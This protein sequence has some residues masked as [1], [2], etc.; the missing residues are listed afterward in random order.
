MIRVNTL[1]KYVCYHP[2]EHQI[3]TT[4]TDR[5][6]GYYETLDAS[7]VR[8]LDGSSGSINTLDISCCGRYFVSAGDDK[9][10]KVSS[11]TH[12]GWFS[13]SNSVDDFKE[14]KLHK[15][16]KGSKR[17]LHGDDDEN[18][19]SISAWLFEHDSYHRAAA[20]TCSIASLLEVELMVYI[21][22]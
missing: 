11:G 20:C 5:K 1:F 2:L 22:I 6:I 9:L 13:N 10:V 15:W 12:F 17:V 8:D 18:D 14:S 19:V 21:T 3:I 16:T 7:T 4:G